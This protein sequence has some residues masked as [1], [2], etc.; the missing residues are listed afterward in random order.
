[1]SHSDDRNSLGFPVLICGL[2]RAGTS[3]LYGALSQ[4]QYFK[5]EKFADK[6]LRYFQ[7]FLGNRPWGRVDAVSSEVFAGIDA[8]IAP[9]IVKRIDEMLR[10]IRGGSHG[11]YLNANPDDIFYSE[12]ILEAVP[13]TK[14]LITLRDPLTNIWSQ[15][16]YPLHTWGKREKTGF[17]KEDT[18]VARAEHWNKVVKHVLKYKFVTRPNQ[19][20]FVEQERLAEGDPAF[21]LSIEQFLGIPGVAQALDAN[22][23][24]IVHSSFLGDSETKFKSTTART[25]H[26]RNSELTFAEEPRY[27]EIVFEVC[28]TNI[29]TLQ[30]LGLLKLGPSAL[31]A[32]AYTPPPPRGAWTGKRIR[33]EL[34][35]AVKSTL[36]RELAQ[37]PEVTVVQIGVGNSATGSNSLARQLVATREWRAVIVE[38]VPR[39]A[40]LFRQSVG[41][42]KI[43]VIEALCV[44]DAD[45]RED[46]QPTITLQSVVREH[47]EGRVNAIVINTWGD[48]IAILRSFDL[49]HYRPELILFKTTRLNAEAIDRYRASLSNLGYLSVRLGDDY[50]ATRRDWLNAEAADDLHLLEHVVRTFRPHAL[51]IY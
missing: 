38:P 20:F 40:E 29:R 32:G 47:A 2:P 37:L 24:L 16:N 50:I 46:G 31:L 4:H 19:F 33:D 35:E 28:G 18:V 21:H 43:K 42:E 15:L 7:T 30:E 3:F 26:F 39:T 13:T 10:S 5:N 44:S 45:P 23:G 1:M 14:F 22:S 27:V 8:L 41:C 11:H 17:F 49:L 34:F 51:E 9:Q 6:E 48:A 36:L 25:E 12:Y